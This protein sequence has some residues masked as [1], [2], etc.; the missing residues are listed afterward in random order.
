[1]FTIQERGGGGAIGVLLQL[2]LTKL[3]GKERNEEDFNLW[4]W[5]HIKNQGAFLFP[6]GSF[7]LQ[8]GLGLPHHLF[9]V[10]TLQPWFLC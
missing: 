7:E 6:M 8:T 9:V 2:W 10:L 4:W 5:P 3:K 1:M